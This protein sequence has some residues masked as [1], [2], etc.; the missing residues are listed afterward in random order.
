M[1]LPDAS[2]NAC[3]RC[4]E[5]EA[6]ALRLIDGKILCQNCE[7][8]GTHRRGHCTICGRDAVPLEWHHIARRRY[9]P[10]LVRAICLNCHAI[11]SA[12][13]RRWPKDIPDPQLAIA[14]GNA[15]IK[16][17]AMRRHAE[18]YHPDVQTAI[19][20]QRV[21]VLRIIAMLHDSGSFTREEHD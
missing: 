18:T 16:A 13:Q 4:G 3:A 6:A 19:D 15:E 9:H 8:P 21:M 11:L 20:L 17:L 2:E 7:P 14:L 1:P 10:T 12:W 5:W